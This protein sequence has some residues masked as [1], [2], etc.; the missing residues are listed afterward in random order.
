[1][2]TIDRDAIRGLGEAISALLPASPPGSAVRHLVLPRRVHPAGVGGLVGLQRDPAGEVL[3][4]RVVG[5][6]RITVRSGDVQG[7]DA[8]TS[9]VV[10]ALAGAGR[11]SLRARGILSLGLV[12]AAVL[13]DSGGDG[14]DEAEPER[15]LDFEVRYE[16]VQPPEEAAGVITEIP[17]DTGLE[18]DGGVP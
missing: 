13:R 6:V 16:F 4:R 17:I 10:E 5:I 14:E 3:G 7:L 18:A 1:M 12:R 8:A 9:A 11:E 15:E 2:A